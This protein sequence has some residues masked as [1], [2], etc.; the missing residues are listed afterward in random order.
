ML[1]QKYHFAQRWWNRRWIWC[2]CKVTLNECFSSLAVIAVCIIKLEISVPKSVL[3][4]YG[5]LLQLFYI[6]WN[7]FAGYIHIYNVLLWKIP[8]SF[9]EKTSLYLYT[10]R[11]CFAL[12]LVLFS[13]F[14]PLWKLLRRFGAAPKVGN[15]QERCKTQNLINEFQHSINLTSVLLHKYLMQYIL[16]KRLL[17]VKMK[18][19]DWKFIKK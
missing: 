1:L 7:S 15:I 11:S 16:S 18:A 4:H 19:N 5:K 6:F 3:Y 13:A 12:L 17:I 14:L 10:L 2:F 9:Y 8:L